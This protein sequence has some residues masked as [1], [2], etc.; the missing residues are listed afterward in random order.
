MDALP[1]NFETKGETYMSPR[2]MIAAKTAHCFEG[3]VFAAAVLAYHG[4]K[5]LLLDFQ[6]I[7]RDEEHVVALFKQNGFWGAISKTNH[8]ILRYRDPVYTSVRELAMTYFHEYGMVDGTKSL[9][10]YSAPFDLSKYNPETWVT[11]AEDLIW[12][13]DTLDQSRHFPIIPKK[14]Q[15]LI[16]K[17]SRI[18]RKVLTLEEWRSQ[19]KRA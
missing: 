12:L 11:P 7:P 16:R 6:T 5:P 9:R 15:R 2:S 14:N 8:A 10:T 4:Q 3:A 1:I 19:G 17:T 18:E 13:V